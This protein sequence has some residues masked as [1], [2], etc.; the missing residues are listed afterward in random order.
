M[1]QRKLTAEEQAELD[2]L[3]ANVEK[4]LSDRK[5]WLD[6]KMHETSSIKP[7]DII[8]DLTTGDA[9]GEVFELYRTANSELYDTSYRC[10]YKYR[11]YYH[12]NCIGTTSMGLKTVGTRDDLIKSYERRVETY[13]IMAERLKADSKEII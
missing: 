9:L 13:K 4:A 10:E 7:G 8:Y 1:N 12:R 2:A 3:N 5:K 11:E 6:A